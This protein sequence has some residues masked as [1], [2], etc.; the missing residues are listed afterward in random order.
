MGRNFFGGVQ[1]HK[2]AKSFGLVLLLAL[3]A[4]HGMLADHVVEAWKSLID[5]G[6]GAQPDW[7][8]IGVISVSAALFVIATVLLWQLRK[9]VLHSSADVVQSDEAGPADGA[10]ILLLSTQSHGKENS[11]SHAITAFNKIDRQGNDKANWFKVLKEVNHA[12]P[13]GHESPFTFWNWQQPLRLIADEMARASILKPINDIVVVC[14]NDSKDHQGD[15]VKGSV[16]S[17][18][19]FKAV[20]EALFKDWPEGGMPN[21]RQAQGAM[22][23]GDYEHSYMVCKRAIDSV[24]G[25]RKNQ[26]RTICFDIS[27][28]ITETSVAAAIATLNRDVR[29]SYVN[30]NSHKP[31]YYDASVTV[32][33]GGE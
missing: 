27:G 29:F 7:Y 1:M 28:T 16:H 24:K 20:L 32:M 13:R 19:D 11:H 30:T 5:H 15:L 6:V 10:I 12:F 31:L 23:I 18:G 14:T 17:F 26:D 9:L 4:L 2:H 8:L 25:N 22:Q 21:I 33:P 3:V